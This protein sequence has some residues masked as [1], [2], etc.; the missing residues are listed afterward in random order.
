M[1]D[2]E[3]ILPALSQS[4]HFLNNGGNSVFKMMSAE[5]FY[6]GLAVGIKITPQKKEH[7]NIVLR[8]P[9]GNLH[10]SASTFDAWQAACLIKKFVLWSFDQIH[11]PPQ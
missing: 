11:T 6:D 9:D 4:F 1:I 3:K 8:L 10:L 5:K 7:G 2:F